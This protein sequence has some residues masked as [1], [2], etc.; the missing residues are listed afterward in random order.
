LCVY[1]LEKHHPEKR[2]TNTFSDNVHEIVEQEMTKSNE[3]LNADVYN[4]NTWGKIGKKG[5]KL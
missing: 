5:S 2:A 4:E 1:I 3:E